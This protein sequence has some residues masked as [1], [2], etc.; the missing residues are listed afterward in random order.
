M[1]RAVLDQLADYFKRRLAGYPTSLSEDE[2]M[3][4]LDLENL[5]MVESLS[6]T[7]GALI[8]I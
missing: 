4:S 2:L 3:V 5:L 1:E 6:I 8:D 7:G